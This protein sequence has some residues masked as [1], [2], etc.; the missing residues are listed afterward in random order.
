MAGDVVVRLSQLVTALSANPGVGLASEKLASFSGVPHEVANEDLEMLSSWFPI[1]SEPEETEDFAQHRLWYY[2]ESVD[3]GSPS[4]RLSVK[5]TMELLSCLETERDPV[6]CQ[7]MK[8][9]L[10]S[11]FPAAERQKGRPRNRRLIKGGKPPFD[12][13]QPS[14]LIYQLA[15]SCGKRRL[16]IEYTNQKGENSKRSVDPLG[17]VYCWTAGAWYLIA[18][19]LHNEEIRSFRIERIRRYR[20]AGQADT[21]ET[22]CLQ[23]YLA[24]AWGAQVT[25]QLYEVKVRFYDDF[26]TISRVRRETQDRRW[27]ALEQEEDDT[28]IYTD[29]ISGL[30]EFRV[31]VRSFGESAEVLEP[32]KLRA[33]L[34]ES[35]QRILERYE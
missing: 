12:Q 33:D 11:L 34:I 8:K 2:D 20:E 35:Y 4:F 5:E 25:S 15:Q 27:G 21:Y 18:Y 14:E 1:Y 31:W 13:L 7:L 6:I 16:I 19:S 23:D 29:L 28:F 3:R 22:F 30:N 17:L 24:D 26:H 10:S 9:L 32:Q